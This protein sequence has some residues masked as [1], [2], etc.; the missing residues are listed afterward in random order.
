MLKK[1]QLKIIVDEVLDELEK[2]GLNNIKETKV[3]IF[4]SLLVVFKL[5]LKQAI[6]ECLIERVK[7]DRNKENPWNI[8]PKYTNPTQDYLESW[9]SQ[10]ESVNITENNEK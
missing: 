7:K 4:S 6:K 8:P 10:Y 3:N 1:D 2:E 5:N 9:K